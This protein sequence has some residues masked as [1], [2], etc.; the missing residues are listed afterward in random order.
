MSS[1]HSRGLSLASRLDGHS[2]PRTYRSQRTCPQSRQSPVHWFRWLS[3][4]DVLVGSLTCLHVGNASFTSCVMRCAR[5]HLQAYSFTS[6]GRSCG[7]HTREH[8]CIE[9]AVTIT[10]KLGDL[11]VVNN[12]VGND[13]EG[14][15]TTEDVSWAEGVST[16]EV[17]ANND[18]SV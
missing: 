10:M 5:T 15:S 2:A 11:T 1:T 12:N 18:V 17:N 13:A 16:T 8:G 3:V 6:E 7:A 14:S 4:T 9:P